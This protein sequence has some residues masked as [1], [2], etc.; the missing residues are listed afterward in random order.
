MDPLDLAQETLDTLLGYLGFVVEITP[1]PDYHT[2]HVASHEGALLIGRNGERLEELTHLLN[3]IVQRH[4]LDA[5]WVRVDV[6]GFLATRDLGMIAEAEEAAVRVMESRRTAKLPPMNSYQRR[7][8][9]HHF[10]NHPG[11]R[12]TSLGGNARLKCILLSP[13]DRS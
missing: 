13:R 2:L 8:I 10:Q 3:R 1:D 6:D 5:P 9:H 4:L 7:L 12:T 11:I